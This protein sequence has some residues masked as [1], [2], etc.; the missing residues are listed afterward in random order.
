MTTAYNFSHED[1]CSFSDTTGN[2]ALSA[3]TALTYMVPGTKMDTYR[4]HFEWAYNAN[5]YVG[6]NTTATVP[7][8]ATITSTSNIEFRPANRFVRGGD[9]ISFISSA[10]VSDG[11]FSLLKIPG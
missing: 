3:N 4:M 2:I 11:G 8:A 5:V 10:I 1:T 7:T 6:F 9:V